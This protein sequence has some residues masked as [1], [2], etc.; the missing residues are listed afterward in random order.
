MDAG[1]L[2]NLI[3]PCALGGWAILCGALA[4]LAARLRPELLTRMDKLPRA[5]VPGA[6]LAFIDLLWCIPN[7]KPI[8][9][10]GFHSAL[11]PAA[12]VLA[13][14][15][16][17]FLDKLLARAAG[18][19]LILLAHYFLKE[20]FADALPGSAFFALLCLAFGTL[21]IFISGKPHLLRDMLRKLCK[22]QTWRLA[23]SAM[24]AALAICALATLSLHIVTG[25]TA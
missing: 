11:L 3:Y 22:N 23:A 1:S 5:A 17:Y 24:L 18:G 10:T 6:I 21:G 12:C 16:W 19:F 2:Q 9:P 8:V 4:V 15:A 14:L 7:V 20:S 25:H 13:I